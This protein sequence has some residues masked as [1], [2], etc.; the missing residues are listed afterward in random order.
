MFWGV[1][2][3]SILAVIAVC[4]GIEMISNSGNAIVAR[5]IMLAGL[6]VTLAVSLNLINGITGQFSMGHAAFYMIGAYA[7]VIVGDKYLINVGLPDWA[8][9]ILLA[10]LGAL[11]AAAAGLVVG[12]PSLRLKGDYLALVTLGF[13]EIIRIVVQ[14][15]PALGGSS[16]YTPTIAITSIA[17]TWGL[18][19]LCIAVCRNLLRTAH[20]L[21]FLAVREDE[22]ASS[23]MGVNVTQVKVTAFVV[24]SAFA[25]AAG[26]LYGL[27]ERYIA[28][29][30]FPMDL[31]F[32]VL[33]MVVLGGTGSITGSALAAIVL[34]Y[35]P[36]RLRDMGTVNGGQLAGATIAV[37]VGV[38]GLKRISDHYHGSKRNKALLLSGTVVGIV[39]VGWILGPVLASTFPQLRAN[40]FEAAKLRMVIFAATLIILMLLRPQGVFAHHEFSW[41]WVQKLMGKR[42]PEQGVSA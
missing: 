31:S 39:V 5:M 38:W 9:L 13:G 37:V 22:I 3:G 8:K 25:G 7:G 32:M 6:Y 35:L 34:F 12:L 30:V 10:L 19:F 16:G 14:N 17:M 23:A 11:I 40:E 24:G 28:P 20:G 15:A 33:T 18:A 2:L 1:R 26:A 27:F 36:E 41:S 42:V 4:F 29:A 21:Q